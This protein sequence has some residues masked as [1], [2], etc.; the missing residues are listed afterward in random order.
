MY[1]DANGNP[2]PDGN[3]EKKGGRLCLRDG[4]RASF[5]VMFLDSARRDGRPAERA[6]NPICAA[7]GR[8]PIRTTDRVAAVG[9]QIAYEHAARQTANDAYVRAAVQAFGRS[10]APR[11][12]ARKLAAA[13]AVRDA[14]RAAQYR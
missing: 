12:D 9:D 14:A 7:T 8:L 1:Y 13:A 2:S 6:V 4:R 5:D 3:Y 10:H 11:Q